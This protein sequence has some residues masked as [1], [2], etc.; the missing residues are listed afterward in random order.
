M[1]PD[2]HSRHLAVVGGLG[3]LAG[4]DLYSKLVKTLA[5]RGETDR[6]RLT[7][8]QRDYARPCGHAEP[9]AMGGREL[10]LYDTL[11]VLAPVDGV[12]LPC[13]MS[14]TVID[15]LQAE[16]QVP[17]VNMMAALARHVGDT[18]RLGILCTRY[19]RE[20]RLFERYF[21]DHALTYVSDDTHEHVVAPAVYGER[22]LL[23]GHTDGA[24]EQLQRACEALVRQGADVI[25]PG[26]S[27][28]AAIA[29]LLAQRGLP[30]V[31]SH[32]VYVDHA[33]NHPAP[34]HAGTFKLG[35]VGG[36]GP[37]ATVD[38]M[39]KIVRHTAATRDQDHLRLIVDHNPQIPDR[40]ANLVG[41]GTD[42][43]LAL[44]SA[45]KRLEANGA[46]AVAMPCNT[47]HA[48]VERIQAGLATPIVNM[49]TETVRHIATHCQGHDTVGLLATSGTIAS[50]VYH[51]AAR[52]TPFGV[53]VPDA[54][55]Q[56]LVM[57]AIYGSQGI[58]AGHT[59]GSCRQSLLTALAHLARRGASVVILGCTE[60]PLV[61]PEHPAF[62][63]AGRSVVLL[64][65]TAILAR[66]C[67]ALAGVTNAPAA[68]RR[69]T[70]DAAMP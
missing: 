62:D 67:V 44:Y 6:Y 11:D 43:T 68:A 39:Q 70:R 10:Y 40:T 3:R 69:V 34:H 60:L 14:H 17:I 1:T 66:R 16:V 5:L 13:F 7:L 51:D 41:N 64:D 19:V 24:V 42:P 2:F 15:A 9:A 50:R 25:I 57:D 23:A 37:A 29:H 63:V 36:I 58:K 30:I 55:H 35:I 8:A 49:L 21:P 53:I 56:A 33:L 28:I 12:L 52:G 65:P 4:A 47:A 32:Q 18:G 59:E 22:G 20:R 27:E 48:Y 61:L 31:D 45:C 46:S 38:F 54:A 26:A